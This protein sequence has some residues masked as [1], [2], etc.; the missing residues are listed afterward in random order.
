MPHDDLSELSLDRLRIL[1]VDDDPQCISM[2]SLA[3]RSMGI[4]KIQTFGDAA[5]AISFM[6][7]SSPDALDSGGTDIDLILSDYVMPEVPGG[8]FPRWV[9]P[10]G[11]SP[12][13]PEPIPPHRAAP[14]TAA[15]LPH[16]GG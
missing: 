10:T 3:L 4:P 12:S 7:S 5:A 2:L 16:R 15:C 11:T 6:K 1:I 9:R 14:R 8:L 13:P